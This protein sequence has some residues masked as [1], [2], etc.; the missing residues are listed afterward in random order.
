VAYSSEIAKVLAGQVAKFVTLNRHQLAGHLANLDFW[1][2]E[3][4][5]CLEVLDGYGPRFERLKAAQREHVKQFGT[6]EFDLR[7][8]CCIKGRAAS[9]KRA[10]DSELWDARQALCD[11]TYRFLLRCFREKLIEEAKLRQACVS[12]GIGVEPNDLLG[13]AKRGG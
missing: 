3:V 11:A 7:D 6:E 9:P 2:A 12:L 13:P 10:P 4:R 5:H 8:P 1:L